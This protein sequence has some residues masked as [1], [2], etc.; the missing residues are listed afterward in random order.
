M[1]NQPEMSEDAHP[2]ATPASAVFILNWNP[3]DVGLLRA[4]ART[5]DHIELICVGRHDPAYIARSIANEPACPEF[6]YR[7]GEVD[8]LSIDRFTAFLRDDLNIQRARAALVLPPPGRSEPDAFSRLACA[9]I[10]RACGDRPVPNIVVAVDDPEAAFEFA[11]HGVATIFHEGF[12]R[13]ALMAHACVD[14]AV[15]QFLLDL[16]ERRHSVQLLP[17]PEDM[18]AQTFR[19]A[20]LQLDKNEAGAPITIL[21]IY[22]AARAKGNGN[23]NGNGNGT[24]ASRRQ[25]QLNPGPKTPLRDAEGLVA[26]TAP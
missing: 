13:S 25:L 20:C 16:V 2:R 8:N 26:L 15:F 21:G 23:G 10:K 5:G 3:E 24:N 6:D 7:R 22:A 19:D 9:A 17:I 14:L 1:P 18:R 11:G 12:L 4:L